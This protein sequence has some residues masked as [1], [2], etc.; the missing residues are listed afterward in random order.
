[1]K[2]HS[3]ENLLPSVE[4]EASFIPVSARITEEI[5]RS[6]SLEHPGYGAPRKIVDAATREVLRTLTSAPVSP[7]DARALLLYTFERLGWL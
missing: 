5:R 1:M 6:G 4:A 7:N 2:S 3:S